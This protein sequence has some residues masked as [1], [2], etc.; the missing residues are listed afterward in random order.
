MELVDVNVLDANV[1]NRV[2]SRMSDVRVRDRLEGDVRESACGRFVLRNRVG[3]CA[4]S[5]R[6]TGPAQLG[7]D[8]L[9]V[10]LVGSPVREGPRGVLLRAGGWHAERPRPQPTRPILD[11]GGSVGVAR[12]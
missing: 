11:L 8:Q 4:R 9:G 12:V 1:G 10:V 6:Y 3:R 7:P 2:H 5:W